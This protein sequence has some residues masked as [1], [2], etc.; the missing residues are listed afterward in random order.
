VVKKGRFYLEAS[1]IDDKLLR[2]AGG[3]IIGS[4]E[5]NHLSELIRHDA[6]LQ[7]LIAHGAGFAFG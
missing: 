3:S 2:G 6:A 4:E 1:A 7:S 5:E